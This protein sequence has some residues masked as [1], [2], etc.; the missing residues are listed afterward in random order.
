MNEASRKVLLSDIMVDREIQ[1]RIALCED[2]IADLEDAYRRGEDVEPL[3]GCSESEDE[4]VWLYDGFNR[5]IAASK[6]GLTA[7]N[8]VVTKGDRTQAMI[9]ACSCNATHGKKRTTE[10]MVVQLKRMLTL[11]RDWDNVKIGKHVH[12]SHTTVAKYRTEMYGS[13]TR[14]KREP[15]QNDGDSTEPLIPVDF[16]ASEPVIAPDKRKGVKKKKPKKE[17]TEGQAKR[18]RKKMDA[19]QDVLDSLGNA[20]PHQLRDIFSD[21]TLHEHVKNARY[22]LEQVAIFDATGASADV[23]ARQTA[24]PFIHGQIAV[25]ELGAIDELAKRLTNFIDAIEAGIPYAVCP[26]CFGDGVTGKKACGDCRA[27][28]GYL[29]KWRYEELHGKKDQSKAS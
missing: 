25:Q 26:R 4:Q 28:C 2:H 16:A 24:L 12:V 8:M 18:G 7:V 19:V 14:K 22:L 11:C 17:A 29:P 1:T 27:K 15:V 9:M 13:P 20:V 23:A 10:E 5:L 6:A 21:Q 3:Q